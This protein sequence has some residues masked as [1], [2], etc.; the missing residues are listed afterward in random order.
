MRRPLG[1][2][3]LALAAL[4][5]VPLGAAADDGA[6]ARMK[7]MEERLLALEDKLEAST[8]TI[9]AQREL[10]QRSA[11]AV[12]QGSKMDSF[13]SDLDIGGFVTGSYS[14]NLNRPNSNTGGSPLCQFNCQHD[15]FTFDAAMFS[16][17]KEAA[18][19]GQAGFQLDLL[20]GENAQILRSEGRSQ[21]SASDEDIYVQEAYVSYNWDGT[22]LKFGKWETLLGYEV[23]DSYRNPN[24]THGILFTWAIPLVHTGVLAQG[25]IGETIGWGLGL[26]NGFNNV[27]DTNDNKGIVGI[28]SMDSG[29]LFTSLSWFYGSERANTP[30]NA[31]PGEPGTTDDVLILDLVASLE[32]SD[33]SSLWLNVDYGEVEDALLVPFG[34]GT[35]LNDD[36]EFWGVA[37][38]GTFALSDKLSLSLRGEYWEDEDDVRGAGQIGTGGFGTGGATLGREDMDVEIYSLTGTLKYQMTDNAVLRTELRY[39]KAEDDL[40]TSDGNIFPRGGGTTGKDESLLG[41]VEVSYIFD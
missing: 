23:L 31:V 21:S 11:P 13:L 35:P 6:A 27:Q 15:E 28:V 30:A 5:A 17:G 26:T 9:E 3:A 10:I 16:I 18:N 40:S 2:T 8:A 29:P 7:S 33:T 22:L 12:S 19:P 24:V 41:I 4:V 39:D 34:G 25:N 20:F 38:G 1:A 36:S 14:Y 37:I 32:L